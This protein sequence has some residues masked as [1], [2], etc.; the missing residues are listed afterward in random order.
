MFKAREKDGFWETTP[1]Q[2]FEGDLQKEGNWKRKI[3][4]ATDEDVYT[5]FY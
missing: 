5:L 2:N 3:T 4:I 1:G